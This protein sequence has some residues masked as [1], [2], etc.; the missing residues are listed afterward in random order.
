MDLISRLRKT[1]KDHGLFMENESLLVAV[2]GGVDSMALLHALQYLG[3]PIYAAHVNYHLRGEDSD[4]DQQAVEDYCNAT[5]I[6]FFVNH[7]ELASGQGIQEKAREARYTWFSELRKD[8]KLNKVVTAHH[9]NDQAETVLFNLCR[10]SGLAGASGMALENNSVVRPLLFMPKEEIVAYAKENNVSYREDVSNQSLKYSRNR[11]RNA[12]FPSLTEVN[13]AFVNHIGGFSHHASQADLLIS[14]VAKSK[15]DSNNKKTAN[16]FQ[17]DLQFL[18]G[19]DYS[20]LLLYYM[21]SELEP[22]PSLRNEVVNLARSAVGKKVAGSNYVFW[23]DRISLVIESIEKE[24]ELTT[25]IIAQGTG[26]YAYKNG[27][28]CITESVFDS[29]EK[30]NVNLIFLPLKYGSKKLSIRAWESGDSIRPFGMKGRQK[31][32]DILIQKK[33]PMPE[34][35]N[36]TVLECE[37]EIL[38]VLGLRASEFTRVV[39]SDQKTLKLLITT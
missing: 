14:E 19:S 10:G 30:P 11:I 22:K 20:D 36:V 28:L 21:L 8:L 5:S 15:W 17:L 35:S 38:W 27:S 16:G 13:S 2:S 34:K 23:R 24:E 39:E 3:Y 18:E 6:P 32:S 4:L 25:E 12:V 1:I 26:V 29:T 37:G 7:L 31:V 9:L 33:V